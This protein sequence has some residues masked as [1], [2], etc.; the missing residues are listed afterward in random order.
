MNRV[1]RYVG[2]VLCVAAA[3][4]LG[5]AAYESRLLISELDTVSNRRGLLRFQDIA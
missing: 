3:L 5:C 1:M 4:T 2:S